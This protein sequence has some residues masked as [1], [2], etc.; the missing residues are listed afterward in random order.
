MHSSVER[1][2]FATVWWCNLSFWSSPVASNEK[3]HCRN[4]VI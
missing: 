3:M 4:I 2:V 1:V